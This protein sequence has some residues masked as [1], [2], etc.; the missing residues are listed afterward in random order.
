MKI[1]L[2]AWYDKWL[3]DHQGTDLLYVPKNGRG[4]PYLPQLQFVRDQ[5]A[6]L[7]W[8]DKSYDDLPRGEKRPDCKRLVDV[9]GEHTSKSVR[10]PVYEIHR[11]DLGIR[12]VLRENYHDW[13]VSVNSDRAIYHDYDVPLD[14]GY[15]FFQGFPAEDQFKA[16]DRETN[17]RRFSFAMSSDYDLY[18]TIALM[19]L[20]RR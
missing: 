2:Q 18:T 5:L 7:L 4:E 20:G 11:P 3:A 9:V 16:Y 1:E 19:M 8:R 12:V 14:F 13:N 15:V 6:P 10:L 17:N